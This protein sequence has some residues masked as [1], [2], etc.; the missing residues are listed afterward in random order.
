MNRQTDLSQRVH[1]RNF[2]MEA[3]IFGNNLAEFRDEGIDPVSAISFGDIGNAI[4]GNCS[5]GR[6]SILQII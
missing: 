3:W 5:N 6:H 2:E 4:N 1:S